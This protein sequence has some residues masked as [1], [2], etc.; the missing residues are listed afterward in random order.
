MS[1]VCERPPRVQASKAT[2]SATLTGLGPAYPAVLGPHPRR[3]LAALIDLG[4]SDAEIA[5]YF[6]LSPRDIACWSAR[7]RLA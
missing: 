6:R 1:D 5:R 4:L 7:L 2:T 3:T